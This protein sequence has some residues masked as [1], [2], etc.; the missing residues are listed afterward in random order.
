[1]YRSK[2]LTFFFQDNGRIPNN[3]ILPVLFYPSILKDKADQAE[4]IFN[5]NNW[6]NSWTNGV[7]SYHHYHSNAHE[8]LG[9]LRGIAIIQLGGENGEQIEVAE[10]DVIIL[11]A[12][13]GHRKVSASSD[14]KIAGAYPDGM[15]YNLRTGEEGERP[16]VLQEIN[17]VP[18]PITDPVYGAQGPLTEHW[19]S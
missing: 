4:S 14:F 17:N 10:G 11:P 3:P 12:G 18:I 15:D 5:Q 6:L 16:Q 13:T 7:F 9:V 19:K 1:M 8:V 2:A